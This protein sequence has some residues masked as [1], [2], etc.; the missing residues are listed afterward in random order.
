MHMNFVKEN[1]HWDNYTSI[2]KRFNKKN[3]NKNF[4]GQTEYF[5][6]LDKKLSR[7]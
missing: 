3:I 2:K 1:L 7:I 4:I 6:K 5:Q